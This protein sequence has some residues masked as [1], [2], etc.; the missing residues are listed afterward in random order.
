MNRFKRLA[1]FSNVSIINQWLAWSLLSTNR[2]NHLL[3]QSNYTAIFFSSII[4]FFFSFRQMKREIIKSFSIITIFHWTS[5]VQLRKLIVQILTP[6]WHTTHTRT[7]TKRRTDRKR[8]ISERKK[9]WFATNR[10]EDKY[11]QKFFFFIL[12][13][14]DFESF[15]QVHRFICKWIESMKWT[16]KREDANKN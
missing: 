13:R 6:K 7:Y 4:Q 16:V 3:A 10:F 1:H 8:D 14:I 5:S 9:K 15:F 2:L 11:E 12:S